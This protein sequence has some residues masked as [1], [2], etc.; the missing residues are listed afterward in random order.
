VQEEKRTQKTQGYPLKKK[1]PDSFLLPI[2]RFFRKLKK[3]LFV[4]S[5]CRLSLSLLVVAPPCRFDKRG[6]NREN[7]MRDPASGGPAKHYGATQAGHPA[8]ILPWLGGTRLG[9]S[10]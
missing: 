5:G 10:F 4:T 9:Q 2:G 7:L 3:M 6:G 8:S 1:L